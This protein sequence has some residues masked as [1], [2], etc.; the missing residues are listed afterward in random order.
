MRLLAAHTLLSLVAV[1]TCGHCVRD[2]MGVEPH[3]LLKHYCL[4]CHGDADGEAGLDL[5]K[6]V[7]QTHLDGTL[8]FENLATGKMPPAEAVQPTREER[9]ALLNWLA[10]RQTEVAPKSFRRISRQEFVHSVNDL[11]GTNLSLAQEIPEDRGTYNFSSDR[12]IQLSR[13]VLSSY[14]AIADR[15]LD[16]ALPEKGFPPERTWVKKKIKDS[17]PTYNIYV[18]DYEEGLV[19]SWTRANNGN[20][21]SFFFDNFEPPVSGWYD[22]T[23]EAA[24]VG[25]F[26]EDVSLQVHAGKYYFADDRPQPQRLSDVISLGNR[27]LKS[28][29]TRVYLNPG[30]NVSVHCYSKHNWRQQAPK[31]GAFIRELKVRGPM[32]DD[33][34]NRVET[35]FGDLVRSTG[36]SR[37]VEPQHN[38]PRDDERPAKAG[39]TNVRTKVIV[40]SASPDALK[41][42]IKRFAERAFSSQ[43]TDDELTPYVDL[44]LTEL[45]EHGDFVRAAKVGFKVVICSPRFLLLPGEHSS[46]AHS[47]V[48]SLA[49]TLWM[50]V[51]DRE[52]LEAAVAT[53]VSG[54]AD[55]ALR[56]QIGRM[57]ADKRSDRMIESLCDQWLNLRSWNKVTPSLKLYPKYDDLLHHYLPLETQAYLAHLIRQNMPV[58]HLIDSAYTFLNQRLAQ[59]Y[60]IDGI[61]G[62]EL[63]KVSFGSDVPRGGL[64]TMA[65]VL[66]VTTDGFDTSPIL[67]GA[68]VSKNIAGTAISPTPETVKAIEPN[69]GTDAKTLRK[70][71]EQHKN[72]ATCYACHKSIDPYGFALENFDSTGQWRDKYRVEKAHKGTF[73]FRLDGY[74]REAGEVDSSGEIGDRAFEDVFGLKKLLVADHRRVGYNFAKS[75]FEYANGYEPSL[76]QR[77]AILAMT[78]SDDVRV[79]KL[80]SDV[81]VYSIGI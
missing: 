15:L 51:P 21:Y 64:L 68:W 42:V 77:L 27:E 69:R 46:A 63:R 4:D 32:Q 31:E 11:L 34:P 28:F 17:H 30:E 8:I 33:L 67:R 24:K 44:P 25:D 22:L 74:F 1:I 71:I 57:L 79:G 66:K 53:D 41:D 14:F 40:E 52:L 2:A 36:F 5:S 81:L 48:A 9:V 26:A 37:Q 13:Q 20:S 54:L 43:L 23:F 16:S 78:D 50:S 18:R 29:S 80:V 6:V 19:F 39:T 35:L 72:S 55:A 76:R 10:E 12:R 60:G 56:S 38:E 59:H 49:R 75:F 58:E 73:Q 3:Q 62:Q 61:I 47:Q 45:A 65:S 7:Q 70:Q